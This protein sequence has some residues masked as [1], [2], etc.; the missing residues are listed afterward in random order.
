MISLREAAAA[1]GGDVNGNQILAPGPGHSPKDRSLSIK[2]GANGPDG[3]V[4]HSFAGDDPIVCE[5]Y[6]RDMLGLDRRRDDPWVVAEYVYRQADGQP[7][8]RVQRTRDKQFWQSY[9]TGSGWAKGKPKG[10]KIPYRLPELVAAVHDTVLICEGEKD[11][12]RL[13]R[14]GFVATTASEGACKWTA[15]LNPYFQGKTA[16]VLADNDGPGVKHAQLVADNLSGVAAEV[17]IVYLPGLPEHG[18]VSDWL[19]AGN[20]TATLID[21]CQTFPIHQPGKGADTT[22]GKTRSHCEPDQSLP[23][24]DMSEWDDLP[25]P[26]RQWAVADRIPLRQPTLLSGEGAIGKTI[27]LLQL[28]VAHV[29]GRDWL[30]TMPEPGPVLYLGAEDDTDELHRRLADITAH[31][32]ARFSDLKDGGLHLLSF[33]GQDALARHDRSGRHCRADAPVRKTAHRR[34]RHSAKIDRARY[35]RRHLPRQRK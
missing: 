31:Y 12:D 32:R 27:L 18:D 5:E 14:L 4:V 13:A 16:Y 8:V 28:S 10:P 17:R 30:G 19:D 11:T 29:L 35:R 7:Y 23:F 20:D 33:A 21:L 24:I 34:A 9:W 1:L 22:D 3:F 25:A 15:D 6:V 2:P 26:P